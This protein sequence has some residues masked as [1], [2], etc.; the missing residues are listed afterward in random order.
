M[1][2]LCDS[3][4]INTIIEFVPN[5]SY[6]V[7]GNGF[8][9]GS[10]FVPS[11]PEY[12]R[13]LSIG[14]VHTAFEW[15]C[16]KVVVSRIWHGTSAGQFYPENHFE[17]PCILRHSIRS[18]NRQIRASTQQMTKTVRESRVI[19]GEMVGVFWYHSSIF[20]YGLREDGAF[21]TPLIYLR[22]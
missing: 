2:T 8:N 13:A 15:N 7:S 9:G 5:C 16:Q 6:S 18:G 10:E 12:T 11:V 14:T 1:C 17:S 4:N 22:N 19:S 20:N 3:T 21:T